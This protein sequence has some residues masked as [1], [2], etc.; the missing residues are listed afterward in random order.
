M[1]P[2]RLGGLREFV[3]AAVLLAAVA[4]V[5]GCAERG[6]TSAD[7]G[8]E[9]MGSVTFHVAALDSLVQSLTVTV[10]ASDIAPALRYNLRTTTPGGTVTTTLSVP[11]GPQRHFRATAFSATGDS[12]FAGET[13]ADIGPAAN[14]AIA[15][16]LY[17]VA[18]A[19][20]QDSAAV[21]DS[22]VVAPV[23]AVLLAGTQAHVIGATALR[24]DLS[25]VF[26]AG[27]TWASLDGSVAAL[28]PDGAVIARQAGAT[29]IAASAG[30]S[31][32]LADVA[33]VA[34]DSLADSSLATVSACDDCDQSVA[35]PF[36]FPFYGSAYASA[37]VSSNG[38]VAF[39]AASLDSVGSLATLEAGPPRVALFLDNLL[40][41][42]GGVIRIRST[43]TYVAIT[44]SNVPR[45]ASAT[46]RYTGQVQLWADGHVVLLWADGPATASTVLAAVGIAPGS[47]G[48]VD[49][50]DFSLLD[51]GVAS[52]LALHGL[53]ASLTSFTLAKRAVAFV[54]TRV[55]SYGAG[56]L[57]LP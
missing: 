43:S 6:P 33:V 40:P 1:M 28:A 25:I 44:W 36:A 11:V 30:R 20:P 16:T 56:S 52:A 27:I 5:W 38:G 17:P 14:T 32:A 46:D 31:S 37:W 9:R 24:A 2:S 45:A 35:L 34:W 22:L 54:P 19:N 57:R 12:L 15:V 50:T 3:K 18:G 13:V 49:A 39:G 26:G 42:N 55:E 47:G 4:A 51:G 41:S 7:A 10:S 48:T 8:P 29:R 21:V 23:L 53:G